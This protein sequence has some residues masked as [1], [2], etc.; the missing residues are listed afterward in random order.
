M[1]DQSVPPV[2]TDEQAQN[3]P[4]EMRAAR[5][6]L[7][8]EWGEVR[9][10][11]KRTKPPTDP[12]TGRRADKTDPAVWTTF[13]EAHVAAKRHGHGVGFVC[14]NGWCGVDLDHCLDEH[15][16]PT[17]EA[18]EIIS[19]LGSYTERSPSRD[20]LHVFIKATLP[21]DVNVKQPFPF[22]MYSTS[23]G[24]LTV[25]GDVAKGYALPV[26]DAQAVAEELYNEF[27]VKPEVCGPVGR[28]R[29]AIVLSD[30][31]TRRKILE[32]KQAEKFTKLWDGDTSGYNSDHSSAD[33]AL[34]GILMFWL[35]GDASR[36]DSWF[37]KS[38]LMR[39]KWDE[40]HGAGTY[41]ELTIAKT[42]LKNTK[43]YRHLG[44]EIRDDSAV[45]HV[46]K[47][48]DKD[49]K[50]KI[51]ETFVCSLIEILGEA[52]DVNN[53]GWSLLIKIRDRDGVLNEHLVPRTM[54]EDPR[55]LFRFLVDHGVVLPSSLEKN[56][57]RRL[58]VQ[59]LSAATAGKRARL[60]KTTGWH[61]DVF[62]LP[63][64][65][66]GEASESFVLDGDR[67]NHPYQ[68]AGTLDGWRYNVAR[69]CVG[70]S[71]MM[72][73]VSAALAG[74]LLPFVTGANPGFHF[75]G[76][77]SQGKTTALCAVSSVCGSGSELGG[78]MRTW[79]A[80]AN[81]LEIVASRHN[82]VLLCLDEIK[83][84]D[85]RQLGDTVYML[86]N[87][88]GKK[89]MRK[90]QDAANV[91]KWQLVTLSSGEPSIEDYAREAGKRLRGG[92]RVRMVD[93]PADAGRGFG[94]F[95]D[96]HGVKGDEKTPAGVIFSNQV[97]AAATCDY[98][99]AL[100][101]LLKQLTEDRDA[102]V[103]QY[104]EKVRKATTR[105][106]GSTGGSESGEVH[107]VAGHFALVAAAGELA[108]EI[109]ITGWS[110]GDAESAGESCFR[111]WF[112]RRGT[113]GS[114]DQNSMVSFVRLLIER[115]GASRFQ[116]LSDNRDGETTD[117]VVIINRLGYKWRERGQSTFFFLPE[118]F[119]QE[120][121][122]EGF[123]VEQVAKALDA[124]GML[125]KS[126]GRLQYRRRTPD[127]EHPR[128]YAIVMLDDE[129][130]LTLLPKAA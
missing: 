40:R 100:R 52:R 68:T 94:V 101:E 112:E 27:K 89:R 126:A 32:S 47:S 75:Y 48:K 61:G 118:A 109:G 79:R 24:Y 83:Q 77:S 42:L 10:N 102:L 57:A 87:G 124:N 25:T 29:A 64:T 36:I 50:P 63:A 72:F 3:I 22:E 45:F 82:H 56:R 33:I 44:F 67:V 85:S 90:D 54:T 114:S 34:C 84:L 6:W 8:W 98:G 96:L 18:F 23:G 108:T 60:V 99:H 92:Q 106:A 43:T 53:A 88:E 7:T 28:A 105:L 95:E 120:C 123:D 80:T 38:G 128:G 9:P 16:A 91:L 4:D 37:R 103:A 110:A 15:G 97:K 121:A 86:G 65:S 125:R 20:G 107:R 17:R 51:R 2:P 30:E 122:K 58:L 93:V 14:I 78:F 13:D 116:S 129:D 74:P 130:Q 62:V 73:A 1:A 115:D 127:G 5:Q 71:R 19:R 55:E 66:F 70:N 31:E 76:Q 39:S 113:A 111:A 81:G 26:A 49:G 41:G 46:G 119:T 117:R 21:D 12:R 59:Y 104:R 35:D 69:L 11:G